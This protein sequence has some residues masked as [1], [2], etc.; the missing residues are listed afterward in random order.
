M[1]TIMLILLMP[2]TAL[3]Q[4]Y[5]LD[6]EMIHPGFLPGSV[7]GVDAANEG[8]QGAF[9]VGGLFQ[10]EKNPLVVL[11][12]GE[13]GGAV[14]ANRVAFDIGIS[15]DISDRVAFNLVL[16]TAASF[17][18]EVPQ[19][20]GDGAGLGDAQI[21]AR[22]FFADPGPLRLGF[23]VDLGLPTGFK[24]SYLG[25]GGVRFHGALLAGIE[26]GPVAVLADLGINARKLVQTEEDLAAGAEL[27]TRL[28]VRVGVVPDLFAVYAGV[29]GKGAFNSLYQGG[30]GNAA[31]A[32]FGVQL[33]P[34]NFLIDIGGGKGLADGYGST[35]FRAMAGLTWI[36]APPEEEVPVP[37][38]PR[39]QPDELTEID[40]LPEAV[41]E[42]PPKVEWKEGELARVEQEAIIIRDQI[43]FEEGKDVILSP[44][45]PAL[46]EI[47]RLMNENGQIGYMIIEGHASNEGS[48]EY[49]YNLS[50]LRARSVWQALIEAGVHPSRI[51]YRGM[52][53]VQPVVAG[54]TPEAREAN[55]RVTFNIVQMYQPGDKIPPLS[56]TVYL[57]WSGEQR[58]ISTPKLPAAYTDP[59]GSEKP[60]GT[61]PPPKSDVN[62][63]VPGRSEFKEEEDEIE[64]PQKKEDKQEDKQGDKQGGGGK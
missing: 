16:P 64:I 12:N 45:L 28:A 29:A 47:A 54:D 51:S 34:G 41:I 43:Q 18:S 61:P 63:G 33:T 32:L 58:T 40:I 55:R 53:E 62:N 50:N 24:Q 19:L 25:E 56:T 27:D 13:D 22:V 35:D 42:L 11:L 1:R 36:Y 49:N 17:G 39:E 7:P 37:V 6:I 3:A 5:S 8:E 15:Y 2:T 59:K 31:E 48:F 44:S 52:G 4:G 9:R 46:K 10:Y 57:P 20:G 26:A 60:K 21:G 30:G 23:K 14:V 38:A